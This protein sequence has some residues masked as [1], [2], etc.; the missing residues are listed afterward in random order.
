[1]E[2]SLIIQN[3]KRK[4]VDIL[5]FKMTFINRLFNRIVKDNKESVKYLF[6]NIDILKI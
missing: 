3:F 5:K 4:I 1:M 6:T 2:I